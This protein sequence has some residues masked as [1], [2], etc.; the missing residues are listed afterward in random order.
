M[1]TQENLEDRQRE[2]ENAATLLKLEVEDEIRTGFK[3][4]SPSSLEPLDNLEASSEAE[5][6][7][8]RE[9]DTSEVLFA[10]ANKRLFSLEEKLNLS[11]VFLMVKHFQEV[12]AARV[13]LLL[14]CGTWSCCAHS[15][16]CFCFQQ[17]EQWRGEA[18]REKLQQHEDRLKVA[19]PISLSH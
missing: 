7:L 8:Q 2:M 13:Q 14:L 10:A 3:S 6:S 5:G 1:K 9:S 15:W 12:S 16:M 11:K 18:L 19:H 4:S 17:D